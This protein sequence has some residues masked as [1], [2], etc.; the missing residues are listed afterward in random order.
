M[1]GRGGLALPGPGRRLGGVGW[2]TVSTLPLLLL[3]ESK[4]ATWPL[5]WGVAERAEDR[6][7]LRS[8]SFGGLLV[9]PSWVWIRAAGRGRGVRWV[10]GTSR[11]VASDGSVYTQP[12]AWAE[13]RDP[14]VC[15][16]LELGVWEGP[17]GRRCTPRGQAG[18][19]PTSGFWFCIE[20][21]DFVELM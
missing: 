5:F 13:T 17:H 16:Q 3:D 12:W 15:R 11:V 7:L 18:Y 21:M 9:L 4:L 8:L 2:V 10:G 19:S 6:W 14:L 1:P 20:T